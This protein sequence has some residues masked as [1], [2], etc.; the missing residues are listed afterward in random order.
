MK[1]FVSPDFCLFKVDQLALWAI[2]WANPGAD[3]KSDGGGKV[4]G[5][6]DHPRTEPPRLLKEICA[7]GRANL[8]LG[9]VNIET[10]KSRWTIGR[11]ER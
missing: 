2:P 8:S 3:L 9:F 10:G 6:I 5:T 7:N 11:C 4:L 1:R